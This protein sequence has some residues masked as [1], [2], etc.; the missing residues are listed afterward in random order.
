MLLVVAFDPE[1]VAGIPVIKT[2]PTAGFY[3]T[4][5]GQIHRVSPMA[6]HHSMPGNAK[7]DAG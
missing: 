2:Q 4:V 6:Y 3:D 7:T 5:L 1:G